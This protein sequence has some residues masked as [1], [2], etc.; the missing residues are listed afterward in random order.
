MLAELK[1]MP[2]NPISNPENVPRAQTVPR[3]KAHQSPPNL[4]SRSS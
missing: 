4:P 1:E 2:G 3:E